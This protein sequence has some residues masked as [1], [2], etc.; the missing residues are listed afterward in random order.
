MWKADD[1]AGISA[2][3]KSKRIVKFFVATVDVRILDVCKNMS[4]AF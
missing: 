3:S 4:G 2:S 1:M